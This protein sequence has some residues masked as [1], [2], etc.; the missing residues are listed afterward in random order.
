MDLGSEH[1]RPSAQPPIEKSGN[2]LAHMSALVGV[3]KPRVELTLLWPEHG[4][5]SH[6]ACHR[7]P[8]FR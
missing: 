3:T 7:I 2:L 6:K 4:I 1:A 8:N 5:I